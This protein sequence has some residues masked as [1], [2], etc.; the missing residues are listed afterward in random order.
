MDDKCTCVRCEGCRGSGQVEYDGYTDWD[1]ELCMECG[2]SGLS[3]ICEL[4]FDR[5]DD[6]WDD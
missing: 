6:D 4:C 2:G 5:R 1:L 3:E